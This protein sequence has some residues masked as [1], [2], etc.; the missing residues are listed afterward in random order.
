MREFLFKYKKEFVLAVFFLV[1][2]VLINI[3]FA[4]IYKKLIDV[5]TTRDLVK[6]YSVV[7]FA[8]MFT[9]L[10]AVVGWLIR[11]TRFHYMKKTLIYLKDRLF[12]AIIKKDVEHFNEVNTGKYISIISNDVKI[13]EED[14]FN[15][16]FRLLGSAVGFVAAL[17]SLFILSYKITVMIILMAILSVIIPRIFDDK[18][19]KMRNDYSESLELFTI[20]SKD[21]L[22]GLEVIKSFGIE[23]KVH[24]KFSK[25]N[26]EVEDKKLKYSVLLNTSD[27]MSEILSSFI[28]LSVF[29][30]GL[31][32]NIR[33][34]MTLG[35]MIACVQ[36]SNSIIM[37]IYSMGQNLNRILSLK[38]ISQKIN[39][40]LQE[41]EEG[42][43]YIPVKS[44]NDSIE[45]KNV[46]FSYTG[47]TKALDNINFTIKKGGKYALVGTSGAGKSTILK[48]LLKQYENYEG[49]IK[50]DGI[51][52]RRI[53]KKDLFKIITLLH[54]NVFIF[55]GTVKDNITLFNDKYTDEEVIRAAKTAGLGPLLEKLPEGILSDV[56]EGGK[57]LS[58]GERQRI[59]IARSIITNASILALDE[60]TAALDN[61]TAY[62]IEKT[63]LGMKDI[64]AIVVTHRL[65][66][67]LLKKYDEIIVLKDGKVIESGK[68]DELLDRKGYFTVYLI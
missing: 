27:T 62:L 56:G 8:V 39:E 65:W 1:A 54:Q 35:T 50:L 66:S 63:I 53:D 59:A 32:F 26:E 21:T 7:K 17:I 29:A 67:E 38:S 6:F 15:N 5:A 68:F 40:V 46:S 22:T 47:E 12:R 42:D 3:Y 19:A 11:T 48:L 37:P 25:V 58:G 24:E 60:A 23:D 13:V 55:D 31:Y 9:I 45:F 41:K 14:Y 34:E 28:F 61:E 10:E 2:S 49:E 36:L 20:E 43:N 16:F 57:L 44:F 18:I 4:F 51:E 33:G 64:T 52:L 30:V